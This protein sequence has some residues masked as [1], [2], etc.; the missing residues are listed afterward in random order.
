MCPDICKEGRKEDLGITC[1]A[2]EKS[3]DGKDTEIEIVD[4]SSLDDEDLEHLADEIYPSYTCCYGVTWGEGARHIATGKEISL[5]EYIKSSEKSSYEPFYPKAEF[6]KRFQN[7][8]LTDNQS[9]F[10]ILARDT[11]SREVVG[12]SWGVIANKDVI[13][14]RI[15]EANYVGRNFNGKSGSTVWEGVSPE[16]GKFLDSQDG[17]EFMY[18][19]EIFLHP[20]LDKSPKVFAQLVMKMID[21]V[22]GYSGTYS[23]NHLFFRTSKNSVVSKFA[24]HDLIKN[25]LNAKSQE[26]SGDE[27][28]IMYILLAIQEEG[29]RRLRRIL[30]L[31]L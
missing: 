11:E 3:C 2:I 22:E 6:I 30:N 17:E 8:M 27:E 29:M 19:D 5:P 25:L 15:G 13:L 16:V 24:R 31:I 10:L 21:V 28:S 9:P 14:E 12:A 20:N 1:K 23:L 7:E 26:V 18:V 4:I